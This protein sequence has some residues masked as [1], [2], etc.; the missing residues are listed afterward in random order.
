MS[1]Q[2]TNKLKCLFCGG[3]L[4]WSS[5]CNATDVCADYSEDDSAVCSFYICSRCGRDYEIIEPP[6][7]E[8]DQLYNNYW[9]KIENKK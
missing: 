3:D 7:E 8:R 9:N 1:K 4:I 6:Q 2:S 5:D